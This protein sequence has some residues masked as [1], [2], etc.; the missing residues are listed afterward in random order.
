MFFRLIYSF[1]KNEI[2]RNKI[3]KFESGKIIETELLMK[4]FAKVVYEPEEYILC[5]E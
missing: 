5:D 3:L 4:N 2:W 1:P